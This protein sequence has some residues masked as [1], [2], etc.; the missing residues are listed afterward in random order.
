M[1]TVGFMENDVKR[2]QRPLRILLV[3]NNPIELSRMRELLQQIPGY[4]VISEIAFDVRSAWQ[5]LMRFTPHF[6]LIDDNIG[7]EE[8]A[9][10]VNSL[11]ANRKTRDVPVAVLKNSN[12]SESITTSAALD[13]LLKQNLSASALYAA[14]KN[15][16]KLKRARQYLMQ[17]YRKRRKQLLK[18][19]R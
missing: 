12:Y 14:V 4:Q 6:I 5:R 13:Y 3:G 18:F 17:A 9:Q 2:M 15:A 8:L 1:I 11:A 16:L 7:K 10:T 19:I